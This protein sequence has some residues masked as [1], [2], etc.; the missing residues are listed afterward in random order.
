MLFRNKTLLAKVE[1]TYATDPTP[2]GTD[3]IL[4]SNLQIQPYAGPTVSR[5]N[6]RSTLGASEQINT[7][8][9]VVLTFDVELAGSGSAGTAPAYAAILTA[10]GFI[11]SDPSPTGTSK[12]YTPISTLWPS[13]TF[14]F[15]HDGQLHKVHGAR[16]DMN[17]AMTKGA[18]PKFSF[19]FTG[20][21][22]T[23]TA[24]SPSSPDVTDYVAPVAVTNSNTPT[25]T[26]GG[27]PLTDLRAESFSLAMGNSVVPR[28]IINAN[29]IH[30]TDRNVTGNAV[31]EAVLTTTKDWF[32]DALESDS[33]INLQAL[34]LIH[35]TTSGNIVQIDAP[36][37]QLSG[38]SQND[39]DGL[40]VY[41]FDMV[42]VPSSGNDEVTFTI[43]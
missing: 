1:S 28:N 31:A 38:V 19:T 21:Y 12:I 9:Q 37:V 33:S 42:F 10:C 5:D 27:S 39:S 17:L 35:G 15:Y 6:D 18:L 32:T 2:V 11:E 20:R 36:A 40:L 25:F 34:Q 23:P 41:S 29:E 16:G 4:T 7:N 14:Y 43:Y 13:V 24:A 3:A 8:P 26:L 30:I 22:A